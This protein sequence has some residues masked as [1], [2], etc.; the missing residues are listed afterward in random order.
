VLPWT[1]APPL[2]NAQCLPRVRG[3]S[4]RRGPPRD[5]PT[6]PEE[7][8]AG[9]SSVAFYLLVS[10]VLALIHWHNQNISASKSARLLVRASGRPYPVLLPASDCAYRMRDTFKEL[11]FC[12]AVPIY[13]LSGAFMIVGLLA[14]VAPRF[15]ERCCARLGLE[16]AWTKLPIGGNLRR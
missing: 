4:L 11:A 5:P 12:I 3:Y 6:T 15:L 1:P 16:V 13:W 7:S 2:G 14:W 10:A 9:R 8:L